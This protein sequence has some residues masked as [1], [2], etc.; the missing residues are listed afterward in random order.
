MLRNVEL[1]Q[2]IKFIIA[3]FLY[4]GPGAFAVAILSIRSKRAIDYLVLFITFSSIFW[5]FFSNFLRLIKLYV[6]TFNLVII[7]SVTGWILF[8]L[9][10]R[11]NIVRHFWSF[12]SNTINFEL[13]AVCLLSLAVTLYPLRN[14][15]AGLGSDSFHH[16]LISE[17]II[18]NHGIPN[19]YAPAYPDIITLNYHIGFHVVSAI[20]SLLSGWDTRFVILLMMPLLVVGSGLAIHYFMSVLSYDKYSAILAA[21]IPL[22]LSSFP[23]G[24]LE[25]GRYPQTLGLLIMTIFITEYLRIME[26]PISIR[27]TLTLAMLGTVLVYTHYRVSIMTFAGIGLW[28]LGNFLGIG[29]VIQKRNRAINLLKVGSIGILILLPLFLSLLRNFSIGYS[30]PI[31][32]PSGSFFKI[33]R[34]GEQNITYLP[35]LIVGAML[36]LAMSVLVIRRDKIGIWLIV[37]WVL[38]I[39]ISILFRNVLT[40]N[41][42]LI[43][44]LISSYI[45]VGVIIG[46]GLSKISHRIPNNNVR[47]LVLFTLVILGGVSMFVR[48]EKNVPISAFVSQ[49]DIIASRWIK[50]HTSRN[51]CFMV[52]TFNFDFSSNFIIGSDGGWWLPLLAQRC[53]IT[54]PMTTSIERFD[55]PQALTKTVNLHRLRGNLDNK[56]ALYLLRKYNIQYVYTSTNSK[57]GGSII[58]PYRLKRSPYFELIYRNQT[59]FVFKVK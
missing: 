4:L 48:L 16:T 13:I 55:H 29:N 30:D 52:N 3:L 10:L 34:L 6:I 50:K 22:F 18:L 36:I 26:T 15:V 51:S 45:P 21:V 24:M 44:V 25:W 19:G 12:Q 39:V 42:D 49:D 37:W 33:T 53:V 2:W 40:T 31:Q 1:I 20:L 35:H 28:E 59:V 38:M 17:L 46:Y 47:L 23:V 57:I 43:T 7:L 14:Q 56:T 54:Y 9:Y 8:F 5:I 32:N 58:D 41:I 27:N 11:R